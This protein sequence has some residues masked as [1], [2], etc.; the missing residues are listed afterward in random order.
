MAVAAV[1]NK[2]APSNT[3]FSS[4]APEKSGVCAVNYVSGK[5]TGSASLSLHVGKGRLLFAA[6]QCD[7]RMVRRQ[8]LQGFGRNA[9]GNKW[10]ISTSTQDEAASANV[11]GVNNDLDKQ[12]PTSNEAWTQAVDRLAEEVQRLK[13]AI[14]ED[15]GD[16]ALL[17]LRETTEQ[18]KDQVEK[19]RASLA[20]E[21]SASKALA[22]LKETTDSL[23]VQAEKVKAALAASAQ[24]AADNS[25]ANLTLIAET[26]PE[27]IRDLAETALDA[28]FETGK[29]LVGAKIHDF[30]LGIPYGG[31]LTAGGVFWFVASGSLHAL[32]F[33]LFLG[34]LVLFLSM[35][36]L[37][38]WRK[39][40]SSLPYI[41]AQALITFIILVREIRR[42]SLTGVIFPTAAVVVVSAAMLGFYSYVYLAGG[43]PPPKKSSGAATAA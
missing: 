17:L 1:S 7:V 32:R 38:V 4:L 8:R 34:G 27:P 18:L 31:L 9:W 43:N 37:K 6:A 26:A 25:K 16:R 19:A 20:I 22:T 13:A 30:C 40:R 5:P 2:L 14:P 39:G 21:Q 35:M 33:G 36:S 12:A 28:H 29:P 24:E 23:V 42:F 41:Q 3:S 15:S 11:E 10:R